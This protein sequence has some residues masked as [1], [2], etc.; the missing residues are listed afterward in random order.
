MHVRRHKH[1]CYV[2]KENKPVQTDRLN[3]LLTFA[4]ETQAIGYNL[5]DH[6]LRDLSR[7]GRLSVQQKHLEGLHI[8]LDL[9][10]DLPP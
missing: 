7:W 4:F 1:V 6:H 5:N 8:S 9:Q 3:G 2:L 10:K